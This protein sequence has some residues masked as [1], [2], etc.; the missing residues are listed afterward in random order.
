M[1]GVWIFL[2]VLPALAQASVFDEAARLSSAPMSLETLEKA[3]RLPWPALDERLETA[4]GAKAEALS[5]QARRAWALDRA[6]PMLAGELKATDEARRALVAALEE[7]VPSTARRGELQRLSEARRLYAAG[8]LDDADA[9]YAAVKRAS[10]LW[11]DAL[12]ERAWTLLLLN[13]PADALGATVSLQAPWFHSEDHAEGR[14][15]EAT[16]LLGKCRWQEARERVAPLVEPPPP[17]DPDLATQV[18]SS[19]QISDSWRDVLTSP[20]VERVRTLLLSDHPSTPDGQKRRQAV[21][22]LGERL[23]R[24]A[25]TTLNQV[26]AEVARR[27]LSVVYEAQRGERLLREE[28][29]EPGQPRPVDPGPLGD[30]EVAWDFDGRWWKDELGLYRYVAGDACVQEAKR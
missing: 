24:D 15:L 9:A 30:D 1:R 27:A 28:G 13:R 11:P 6:L 3:A 21:F 16:V 25:I 5:P 23:V 26:R 2:L 22:A 29:H 10:A 18:L 7:A 19:S 14:L 20:L 8:R 12:R 4:L 17:L